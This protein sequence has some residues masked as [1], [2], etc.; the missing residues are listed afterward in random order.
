MSVCL[1]VLLVVW[2]V[3]VDSLPPSAHVF[4]HLIAESNQVSTICTSLTSD[5]DSDSS[6]PLLF[7][8]ISEAAE[9]RILEV[10]DAVEAVVILEVPASEVG[11]CLYYGCSCPQ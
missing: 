6:A 1:L 8:N 5:E 3:L 9:V 10:I 2:L 11:N 7:L 4:P